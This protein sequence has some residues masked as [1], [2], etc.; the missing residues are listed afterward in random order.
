M[1]P[2]QCIWLIMLLPLFSFIINGL[3]IRQFINRKSR[4]Y[5]YVAILAIGLAA[6]FSIWSL[7]SVMSSDSHQIIIPSIHWLTIGNFDFSVGMMMDQV[8]AIMVV[9]VSV[10]SL[11]VQIYSIG[12]MHHDEAGYYRY[13]TYMSLFTFAMLG[14]VLSNNLL[15]TFVFWEMVGLCSYLLIGFWFHKKSAADAAKKA[16][17]VT[18]IG[19]F[20]FLAGILI[21]FF[22]TH[23]LDITQLHNLAITGAFAGSAL[24]W[25]CCRPLCRGGRQER[26][27]PAARLAAGRDGRPDPRQRPHP[28]RDNGLRRRLPGRPHDAALCILPASDYAGSSH[29]RFYGHFRRDDGPG[30]QRYQARPRLLHDQPDR[31]HDAGAGSGRYAAVFTNQRRPV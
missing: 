29:R 15:F 12:Y 19:D 18:R 31:L 7:V 10:V 23:M 9:V 1:I 4:V 13:Y 5:G 28:F 25:A 16:F 2:Y 17:I 3:L 14:L 26:P 30:S 6:A 22:N 24:T 11:M 20:G 27:V 8:S 21:I